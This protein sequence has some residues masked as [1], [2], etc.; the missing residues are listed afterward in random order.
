MITETY[1]TTEPKFKPGDHVSI[2]SSYWGRRTGV[3]KE[4][5]GVARNVNGPGKHDHMYIYIDDVTGYEQFSHEKTIK[6]CRKA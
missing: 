3:I 4:Y 6:K 1:P 5:R 2:Y